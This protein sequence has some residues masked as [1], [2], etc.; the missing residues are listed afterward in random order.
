MAFGQGDHAT[1]GP[2][3][4]D[5]FARTGAQSEWRPSARR[6]TGGRP[7]LHLWRQG[8]RRKAKAAACEAGARLI[9]GRTDIGPRLPAV[10]EKSRCGD[11]EVDPIIGKGHRGAVLTVVDRKSKHIRLAALS[12]KTSAETTRALIRL[13]E[14]I[15]DRLHTITADNGKEVARHA[16]VAA[17]LGLD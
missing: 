11:L 1:H 10:D 5:Y 4:V 16:E 13:P 6:A 12:A 8:K 14:P 9:P 15:N 17:T 7:Y 2:R 3:A